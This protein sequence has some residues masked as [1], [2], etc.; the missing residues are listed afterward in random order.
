MV[1]PKK[2]TLQ[3]VD[4]NIGSFYK[5]C[6]RNS[7]FNLIFDIAGKSQRSKKQRQFV[8]AK[9]KFYLDLKNLGSNSVRELVDSLVLLGGVSLNFVA[10]NHTHSLIVF[11]HSF[12]VG[13]R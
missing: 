5:L 13:R 4:Q 10:S 8:F 7:T 12:S 6:S 9:R 3:E 11:L 2:R 1:S